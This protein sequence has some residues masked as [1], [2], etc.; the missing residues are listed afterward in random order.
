MIFKFIYTKPSHVAKNKQLAGPPQ[1]DVLL[2]EI[3]GAMLD[4]ATLGCSVGVLLGEID[5]AMLDGA[6]LGC[7]VGVSLGEIDG[8]MLDGATVAAIEL[9]P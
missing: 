4:G 7:S 1:V 3:E 2:G 8:A 5:G 9:F 6:T